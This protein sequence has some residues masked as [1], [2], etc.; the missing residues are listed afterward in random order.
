MNQHVATYPHGDD[1]RILWLTKHPGISDEGASELVGAPLPTERT[2]ELPFSR[3][4]IGVSFDPLFACVVGQRTF[5][6][7]DHVS[8]C[9]IVLDEIL[10]TDSSTDAWTQI[11][12]LKDRY[13]SQFVFCPSRP[14]DAVRSLRALDGLSR[15]PADMLEATARTR[16]PEFVSF[17]TVAGVVPRD[18]TPVQVESE[19]NAYL[20]DV[21]TRPGSDGDPLIGADGAPVPM[22][23]FLDDFPVYRTMQSVR[24]NQVGG[25]TALYLAVRGLLNSHATRLSE[26]P[27]PD[28]LRARNPTGY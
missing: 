27:R 22:I 16:W 24:T 17:D 15:Y 21:V 14:E 6:K 18:V 23:L 28:H 5:V 3:T 9:M 2:L 7:G 10:D 1:L 12:V 13:R 26:P 19:L 8:S 4:A 20:N 11:R 25:T